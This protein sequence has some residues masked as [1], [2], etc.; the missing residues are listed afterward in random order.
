MNLDKNVS[1]RVKGTGSPCEREP[2]A[3]TVWHALP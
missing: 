2:L 3:E 1:P